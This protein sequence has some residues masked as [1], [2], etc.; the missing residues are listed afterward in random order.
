MADKQY[1]VLSAMTYRKQPYTTGMA[2]TLDDATAKRML[3]TKL[4]AEVEESQPKPAKPTKS[5]PAKATPDKVTTETT[6]SPPETE[7]LTEIE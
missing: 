3:A 2:I 7:T 4:V 6:A 1:R 5:K